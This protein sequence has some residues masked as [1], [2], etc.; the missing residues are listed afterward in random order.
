MDAGRDLLRFITCGSVDDGKSTLI[1]RLLYDAQVLAEDQLAALTADSCRFGTT[2]TGALDMA[3]LVDGLQAEREQGI[4]IDVAYRFF[5]TSRRKFIV[6]DTPG[7][8][9]YTRNMVTGAAVAEA[10]VLLVDARH[11]VLTQTR[12]HAAIVHLMGIRSVAVAVNKMDLAGWNE[13]TFRTIAAELARFA[14]RLGMAPPAC[15][16]VSA[17]TGDTLTRAAPKVVPWYAGPTLLEWLEAVE[18]E[19]TDAATRPF[20]MP[21]QWVNRPDHHFRGY[22]GTVA[23][24][25]VRPGDRVV[26]LPSG[27]ESAVGRIVTY[28]GDLPEAEAGV[29]VT[30]T[31]V[32][33][34]DISRGDVLADT[35]ERPVVS[36]QFAAHVVWMADEPLLPGRGY[37]LHLGTA[38]V[39]AQVTELKYRMA[40]DSLERVAT[41]RLAL[42][43]IGFC[44][45]ALDHPIPFEPYADSRALGGFILIDRIT[46]ATVGCG[47]IAFSLRRA[48]NLK[49]YVQSVDKAARAA[50]KGQRPCVLWFT[51]LSGSGKSTVANL[52]ERKLLALGH[53]TYLLDGEN[54]RR[55]LNKGLGFTAGDR[56]E[57]IRRIGECAR[58]FVDAGLIVL[59]A[60]ISPFVA[61]RRMARA[62]L[63]EDEFVEIFLDVPLEVCEARD[64]DG[65]YRKARA[66]A[67]PN[68]TGLD[69]PYERPET[70][71][72]TLD[73]VGHDAEALADQVVAWLHGEGRI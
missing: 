38:E 67:L 7:H 55:G 13:N 71:D 69:S 16:P 35:A 32:D 50:L 61:E 36:D 41:R 39:T 24:G 27:R 12:R 73:G 11:G 53:H 47:M 54:L 51:G 59:A 23:A 28:D 19:Q 49:G 34:V 26:V 45:F 70:P 29:A 60:F 17:L 62:L 46:N 48:L 2:G 68:F 64:P 42:N 4:T 37:L 58:L 57:N 52:V 1:G 21:V 3:L 8:E 72:L 9:Q 25:H 10:A 30:L 56:V 63:A 20:R 44:N 18:P 43:D 66:G 14:D 22:C 6:A 40:V 33:Q 31:L 15:F 5:A 65:L